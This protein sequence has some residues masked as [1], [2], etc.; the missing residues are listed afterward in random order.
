VADKSVN[1]PDILGYLTDGQRFNVG[2]VQVAL[3]SRPRIVRAGRP[4]EV[5]VL[6]QNASDANV[7]LTM[8]LSLPDQDAKK[9]KDKFKTK[10]SRLVVG[11]TPGEVGYVGLPV[12]CAADTAPGEGYKFGVQIEA[13]PLSKPERVRSTN[14]GG[15]VDIESLTPEKQEMLTELR[16][17][18]FSVKSRL[19]LKPIVETS[20]TVMSG[21]IGQLADL[22]PGWVSLW[23]FGDQ[24]DDS[25]FLEKYGKLLNDSVM[26]QLRRR[27]VYG[28]LLAE[29]QKRF[30]AAGYPLLPAE[31]MVITKL[32]T[33][34][35]EFGS[36]RETGHGALMAGVYD[37][38]LFLESED[39]KSLLRTQK[40][41]SWAGAM[42]RALARDQRF[43]E[44]PIRVLTGEAYDNL[45]R[46]TIRYAFDSV[47][48]A[49]GENLGS[50]DEMR[51]YAERLV[52]SLEDG[53]PLDFT[54]VYMPLVLGGVLSF[55]QIILPEENLNSTIGEIAQLMI[56]RDSERSD[57][58]ELVFNIARDIIDRA[59]TKYGLGL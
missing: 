35:L 2:V 7:D 54:R 34:I 48:E 56:Q 8:I 13:K 27:K 45:L 30:A 39:I 1:Y 46:D 17:L 28:P 9:Q 32:L 29:T 50:V 33:L 12:I 21:T 25:L 49:T 36:P 53:G 58:N 57:D 22:Q 26:P 38:S 3:A 41:P 43:A 10:V 59:L 42:L 23:T 55:D 16:K 44:Q 24:Q 4:F 37:V 11:L 40:L 19:G 14:G 47:I 18:H 31:A 15:E 5:I 20:L 51:E 6:A 52:H